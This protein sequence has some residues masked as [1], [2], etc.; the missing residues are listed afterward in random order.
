MGV[1]HGIALTHGIGVRYPALQ[2]GDHGALHL[3]GNPGAT[4]RP[5]D[6]KQIG[7]RRTAA[8]LIW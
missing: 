2:R 8:S 1:N 4:V 7:V 3:S 6:D 5:R